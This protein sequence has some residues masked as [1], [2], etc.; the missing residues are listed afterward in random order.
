MVGKSLDDGRIHVV[1]SNP[2]RPQPECEVLRGRVQLPQRPAV[3]SKGRKMFGI[4]AEMPVHI[5]KVADDGD[6]APIFQKPDKAPDPVDVI[7]IAN[8]VGA[9]ARAGAVM[10]DKT[11][12]NGVV[13]CGDQD[14]LQLEPTKKVTGRAA[15]DDMGR[16]GAHLLEK[17]IDRVFWRKV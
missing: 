1:A 13:N 14:A 6:V 11:S 15:I 2:R 7:G 3:V 10:P 4:P 16:G 8:L 17:R 5:R 9:V 12:K